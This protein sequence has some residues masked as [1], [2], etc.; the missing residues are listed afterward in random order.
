MV[1][2]ADVLH[3][4]DAFEQIDHAFSKALEHRKPVYISIA[5]NIQVCPFPCLTS[6]RRDAEGCRGKC[7]ETCI[8]TCTETCMLQVVSSVIIREVVDLQT[9]NTPSCFHQALSKLHNS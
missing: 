8:E 1:L 9:L 4:E 3:V 6:Q 7:R 2:Q 5:A